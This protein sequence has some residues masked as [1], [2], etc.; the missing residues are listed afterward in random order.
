MG[1][2]RSLLFHMTEVEQVAVVLGSAMPASLMTVVYTREN[3]RD[4]TFLASMLSL[5]LPTSLGFRF[6]LIAP[7]RS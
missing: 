4:G 3:G 6:I 1:L 7:V 2:I 5:A